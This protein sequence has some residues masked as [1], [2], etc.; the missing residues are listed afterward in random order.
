MKKTTIAAAFWLCAAILSAQY[1][2]YYGKNKIVRRAFPWKYAE[3][4]NF[5]IYHYI[6]DRDLLSRIAV[7]AEK[8]YEKLSTQL[9]V[10]IKEKTPIIFYD[11]QT[12]LE[13]TNLYPG[14]IPPGSFEGF[15]EPIGHRVV[16]YGNRTSEELGRLIIHELSHSFQHELLY[17]SRPSGMFDFNRP[18][19]WVMEGHAEFM[20]GYWD[21]FSLMTVIDAV[22]NDRIPEVQEDGDIRSPYATGRTP[23]DFGH[24]MYEFFHERFGNQGVRDLLLSQRR[25]SLVSRRRSFLEQFNFVPKTFN[26]EFKRYARER[27]R[28]FFTRENPESYSFAIGPDFPFAYSFSHQVSPGGE[29]LAVVTVNYRSYKLDIILISLKDGKVIKNVT[30]GFKS[31]YDGI[32]IKFVPSDGRSFCWDRRGEN[33][34]FFA[35]KALDSYLVVL[36]AV[37]NRVRKEFNVGEIQKPSSPVFHPKQN[38][39]LF[40]GIEG[41]HSYLYSLDLDSGEVRKLSDGRTYIKAVDITADGT[42]VVYS[43]SAGDFDKLYLAASEIPDQAVKLTDGECNDIAPAFSLDGRTVYFSSDELGAYNLCSLDLEKK[44]VFR[45]SDV[46][47]GNF[48]PVEVPGRP[49]EVVISSYHKGSFMLFTKDVTGHL[50]RQAVEFVPAP[51]APSAVAQVSAAEAGKGKPAVFT[52]EPRKYKPFEKLVISGLPPVTV[53]V[54]TGGGF[55]GSSYLNVTDMLG[56]HNFIFYLASFYGYRSY[57]LAYLNQRRRLQ[58]Y[59]HLFSES[60]AYYY[61]Y[62]STLYLSLRSRIGGDMALFYPLSRSTRAELSLS[63]FHQEEDS[64]LLYYGYELPYG[65]FFNGFALPLEASLV[66]ETTRFQNY[67]PNSGHTFRLSAGKYLKL[68]SNSLDAYTLEGDFRKYLRLDSNTLLAFRLAGFTSGGENPLLFWSGGN[69]TLR[70]A[71]F[72][73]LVGNSGFFVNAEFRF[74]LVHAALTPIGIVGPLRGTFFFDLGGL[75]FQGEDFRVFKSGSLQLENALSSY[76]YGIEFFLFGYPLHVEWVYRTDLKDSGYSGINFWIGFDF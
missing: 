23:Y 19:L 49:G 58:L 44:E 5:R 16:I 4:K 29:L 11:K 40:T 62:S 71:G 61:P 25:P 75:W 64:D 50:A 73:S 48:F 59:G 2:F 24:L 37:D 1:S 26:Y 60:D 38:R 18:P 67:G 47:T 35:R 9:N 54:D 43:A 14:I 30:P 17:K 72:R 31:T 33:I 68:F 22:V 15:T 41:L 10:A 57:H 74:P 27:F 6:D 34:A 51:A 42:K 20:T 65:Q 13:Q 70:T 56:D 53:G 7:E 28:S 36:N 8:A 12:D 32:Q 66:C 55:Y 45:H 21:S 52:L 76:G 46:R 3:T 69:N 39:L 63:A